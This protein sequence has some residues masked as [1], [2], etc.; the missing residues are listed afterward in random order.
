[1]SARPVCHVEQHR[2][3]ALHPA[4]LGPVTYLVYL[5]LETSEVRLDD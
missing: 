1:M 5:A 4:M 2:R 3:G